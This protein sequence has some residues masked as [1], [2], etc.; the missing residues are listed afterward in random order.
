MHLSFVAADSS[1]LSPVGYGSAGG[2]AVYMRELVKALSKTGA[3]CTTYSCHMLND[4]CTTSVSGSGNTVV[5]VGVRE[6]DPI[7]RA[8]KFGERIGSLLHCET[9]AIHANYWLGGI[10]ADSA[11]AYTGIPYLV[12]YHSLALIKYKHGSVLDETRAQW[13]R[14]LSEKASGISY[15]WNGERS[16]IC[17]LYPWAKN[18]L[19]IISPGVRLDVFKPGNKA[20]A[21]K[22]LDLNFQKVAVCVG[23]V[24]EYKGTHIA[25]QALSVLENKN[26]GLVIIGDLAYDPGYSQYLQ[27][28]VYA[29]GLGDRVKFVNPVEHSALA[30]YYQA[31]DLLMLPS[32]HE[33]FGLVALEAMACGTP[34]VVSLPRGEQPIHSL[35]GYTTVNRDPES[36]A[37]AMESTLGGRDECTGSPHSALRQYAELFSWAQ[38]AK[39]ALRAYD[40]L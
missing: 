22:L 37:Q 18:R 29:H 24:Q 38:S 25:I 15:A 23:R 31:A 7:R 20:Q 3:V 16:D 1:A 28:L 14:T 19:H 13:E 30:S 39:D 4:D 12:T 8:R 21:K 40:T 32:R 9:Q 36:F 11:S 27:S 2:H 26:T 10:S 35:Q 6:S 33:S 5:S 34:V 17:A